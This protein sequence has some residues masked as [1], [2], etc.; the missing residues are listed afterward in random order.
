MLVP[1][2][3]YTALIPPVL[4]ALESPNSK[5]AY[6]LALQ[7]FFRW[8][9]E[10][11]PAEGLSRSTLVTY[12]EHLLDLKLAPKSVNL[13]L[14]AIKK[15]VSEAA[16]NGWL[17]APT[18][19]SLSK[20]PGAKA[21]KTRTGRWL[22]LEE[23]RTLLSLPDTTTLIGKRDAAMLWLLLGCGLRRAEA[24]GV[25][26][27]Q[28]E[29]REGRVILRDVKGKG[30]KVRIVPV[31]ANGY[32][33]IYDWLE[34]SG[35]TS[36]PILRRIKPNAV[37]GMSV[38]DPMTANSIYQRVKY[39]GKAIGVQIAPHDLRRTFGGLARNGGAE[40]GAIQRTYGHAS[41][42]TTDKYL[43]DIQDFS[44]SPCDMTGL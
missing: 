33:A 25:R 39:W 43:G 20:V 38:D 23:A 31:P 29:E 10:T 15:L 40:I 5:K 35:L 4:A 12:R 11:R 34:H 17:D 8:Y 44:S 6:N 16:E 9:G 2:P 41:S 3:D 21:R 37:F 27:E 32:A 1:A 18:A 14:S 26:I 28:I 30:E 24:S 42:D 19:W 13:A 7:R 22:T 36:G